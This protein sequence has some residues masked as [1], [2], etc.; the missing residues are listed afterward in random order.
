MNRF[1]RKPV[2]E[3]LAV[4]GVV[5]FCAMAVILFVTPPA[6]GYEF[7]MYEGYPRAFWL[8]ALVGLLMSQFVVL[9]KALLGDDTAPNLWRVSLATIVAIETVL[10]LLPYYRGYRA[11]GRADVLTHVGFIKST[12]DLGTLVPGDIYPNIHTLALTISH[13]TGVEPLSLINSLAVV[14]PFFSL[15]AWYAFV[16]R[17]YDRDRALLTLP[18][19]MLFVGASAYVNPS[20]YTQSSLL[21]PFVLYLFVR[22]RQTRTLAVRITLLLA[23]VGITVYHPLTALFLIL[24]LSLYMVITVALDRE[25]LEPMTISW[26]SAT[27]KGATL[28]LMTALFVSWYYGTYTV[29]QKTENALRPLL[30]TTNGQS[31]LSAISSTVQES[32][33]KL[34]DLLLVA[35]TEYGISAILFGIAGLYLAVVVY[36]YL[37]ERT[38]P[39]GYELWFALTAI[40]FFGISLLFLLV[41]LPTG[42]G[43][44]LMYVRLFGVLLCGPLFYHLYQTG[45]A[46]R[47]VTTG[48]VVLLVVYT[49]V[50]VVGLYNSPLKVKTSHQVTDAEVEGME[51]FFDHRNRSVGILNHGLSARRFA[52][53]Y[54]GVNR[55][56]SQEYLASTSRPPIH[57]SYDRNRTLGSSYETDRYLILVPLGRQFY[58]EMYPSYR[59]QWKYEPE[60]FET[61]H[62][63]PAVSRV[64]DGGSTT[65][66][67][68]TAE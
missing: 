26:G 54:Y 14:I 27:G 9:R 28:H 48:L 61:L 10:F 23:V 17:L 12:Q 32:S 36:R 15:L 39:R 57:Y 47:I 50:G 37:V 46:Y 53:A 52:D 43:R 8:L 64:H 49:T 63:D 2:S 4:G 38:R 11:Y 62:R 19:A 42:W 51:W 5:A 65:I 16:T 58:P 56:S 3:L 25:L 60:D 29:R 66:Y 13:A 34:T 20:P 33:P 41:D 68:V 59:D 40:A 24:G 45:D 31:Q 35:F 22:E 7:S 1:D 44:P 18:F 21:V 67:R 30:G 55:S 6:S